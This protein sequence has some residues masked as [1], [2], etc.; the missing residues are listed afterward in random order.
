MKIKIRDIQLD[1]KLSPRTGVDDTVISSY[2]SSFES[3]PPIDVFW[4]EGK[5]GWWLVDG[6]HRLGAAKQRNEEEIEATDHQGTMID[7]IEYSFDANLK[8]GR[9]L[10]NKERKEAARFKLMR[11]TVRSNNWIGADCGIATHTVMAIRDDL[12]S[13]LQIAKLDKLQGRDKKWYPRELPK[14]TIEIVDPVEPVTLY[15]GS[16]EDILPTLDTRFDLVIADPPYGVEMKERCGVEYTW[17]NL[18]TKNWL[19]AIKSY[20]AEEY[21]LFW[22]CSPSFSTDIEMTFREVGFPIQSRLVWHRRNMARGSHAKNKF[23]DTWDMIFHVGNK[24]LNFPAGWT[25]AWFDVQIHA[26][27]QSNFDDKKLHPTQKPFS[28]IKRLVEF[29]SDKDGTILDPFAGGGTT[30]AA[31]QEDDRKCVLIEKEVGYCGIIEGRLG[32]T[33]TINKKER[34]I[35]AIEVNTN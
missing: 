13:A 7:A 30:G 6:W 33:R 2:V 4:I 9:P 15:L 27:P 28:L 12:E 34:D 32:I 1:D 5:D 3:L 24:P 11:Y 20:L 17:D 22:F 19:E 8:H 35:Y 16:M 23:I 14:P 25:D 21:H 10:T 31:C 26:I 18:D 29:G